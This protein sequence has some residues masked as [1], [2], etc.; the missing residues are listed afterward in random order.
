MEST[1]VS[2]CYLSSAKA[3]QA[4]RTSSHES[5]RHL[6]SVISHMFLYFCPHIFNRIQVRRATRSVCQVDIV[7]LRKAVSNPL[8]VEMGWLFFWNWRIPSGYI[9]QC[10]EPYNILQTI[11]ISAVS[12]SRQY[13]GLFPVL[14][15]KSTPTQH[16]NFTTAGTN[17]GVS[18]GHEGDHRSWSQLCNGECDIR[19][20]YPRIK[21]SIN[22]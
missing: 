7:S 15:D 10:K 2:K 13:D 22:K 12:F 4:S 11:H 9:N 3:L 5:S 1:I 21:E 6:G 16:R 14:Y 18:V 20:D 8:N 19:K 17:G